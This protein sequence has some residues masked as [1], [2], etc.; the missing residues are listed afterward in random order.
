MI[1]LGVGTRRIGL[2]REDYYEDRIAYEPMSG[3]W[4]WMGNSYTNGYGRVSDGFKVC[5]SNL[6]HRN[7]FAFKTG[8]N[9]PT[10]RMVL[11]KCNNKSCVNPSHLYL[12]CSADNA[13]DAMRDGVLIRDGVGNKKLTGADS[14]NIWTRFIGGE[15][16]ASIA[17]DFPSVSAQTIYSICSGRTW[18]HATQKETDNEK[19]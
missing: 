7:V 12:G 16:R 1:Y 3:C 5:K 15:K 2:S 10:N 8:L 11:H 4:L 19:Q 17:K 18:S 13:R 14:R 9:P 6:A